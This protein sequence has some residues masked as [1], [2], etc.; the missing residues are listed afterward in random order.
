MVK[1]AILAIALF[2]AL[3]LSLASAGSESDTMHC[4]VTSVVD[5]DTVFCRVVEPGHILNGTTQEV[6]FEWIDAAN[7]KDSYCYGT[8]AKAWVVARTLGKTVTLVQTGVRNRDNTAHRRLLRTPF[9]T[10]DLNLAMLRIGYVQTTSFLAEAPADIATAYFAA[11]AEA[12]AG[13]LGIW[14]RDDP[15]RCPR[16]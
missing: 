16:R 5:G 14:G 7:K 2:A 9:D 6:R 13:H 11:E 4:K 1:I 10:E 8:Q 3:G 12:Q 15:E